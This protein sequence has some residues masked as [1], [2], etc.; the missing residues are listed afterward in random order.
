MIWSCLCFL[1]H[2]LFTWDLKSFT[3]KY[4]FNPYIVIVASAKIPM[5]QDVFFFLLSKESSIPPT[6]APFSSTELIEP[7]YFIWTYY[8]G[9]QWLSAIYR[10]ESYW[11]LELSWWLMDIS[12]LFSTF[13]F[14][15]TENVWDCML[16]MVIILEDATTNIY[17]FKI[18][19]YSYIMRCLVPF[20]FPH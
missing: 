6:P 7:P 5:P 20:C 9:I 19:V 4:I 16:E 13:I 1:G 14:L 3:K 2:Q 12:L 18:K 11:K 8:F 10:R 17:V 15:T